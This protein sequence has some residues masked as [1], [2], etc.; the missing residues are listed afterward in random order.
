MREIRDL[1][2]RLASNWRDHGFDDDAFAS[3]AVEALE[4]SGLLRDVRPADLNAWF[5]KESGL[6]DQSF[7]N[8]GQPAL[9][10]FKGH[11]FYI[12]L[13]YW[14]E[15]TTAIHQ[16]SFAGAFGVLSGSSLHSR[17]TFAAEDRRKS[18]MIFGDLSLGDVEVLSRG[19]VRPILPG[20]GLIHSLF[21][22]DHPTLSIVV[23]TETIAS[24]QPQYSYYRSGI[25]HDPLFAPEPF[26]TRLRLLVALREVEDPDFWRFSIDAMRDADAWMA[27]AIL[28]VAYKAR[29]ST[30]DWETLLQ[31][32]HERLGH[33]AETVLASLEERSRDR[34]LID[35]RRDVRDPDLRFFLALLLNLPNRHAIYQAIG[36]RFPDDD[37]EECV[38]RWIGDFSAQH[39]VDIEF[40]ALGLKMLR[41][42]LR[43]LPL[44][45]VRRELARVFGHKQ[46]TAEAANLE[47]LWNGMRRSSILAPL[48]VTSALDDRAP[49]GIGDPLCLA[50][51]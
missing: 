32:A 44:A 9:T 23:R 29:D 46:V 50:S 8:F 16:H 33:R 17:Y 15:S 43:D 12:E 42:A 39:K 49:V 40:D 45:A 38:V 6:P 4:A 35:Q 41:Y 37:P 11:R 47:A 26:S 7:R 24:H 34:L 31:A 10:L 20:D 21:H 14:L 5:L 27:M 19:D 25:G 3:I 2:A 28:N 22:L 13:L 36:Q 1:G 30:R 48:F 18:A 51:T